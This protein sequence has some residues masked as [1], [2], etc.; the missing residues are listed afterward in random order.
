[1]SVCVT[2]YVLAVIETERANTACVQAAAHGSPPR[3]RP[4]KR[5]QIA[6]FLHGNILYMTLPFARVRN[7]L[8]SSKAP[9]V[10]PAG[11]CLF[12]LLLLFIVP[13][14][15]SSRYVLRERDRGVVAIPKNSSKW[16]YYHRADAEERMHEHMPEGYV[17][18]REEEVVVGQTTKYKEGHP[19]TK[20]NLLLVSF[21]LGGTRGKSTVSDETEYRLYYSRGKTGVQQAAFNQPAD[22]GQPRSDSGSVRPQR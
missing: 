10:K 14:C 6:L 15:N 13:A 9:I 7:V 21:G 18:E 17:V 22:R 5:A 20:I 12:L 2:A 16:P 11:S 1:M 19:G 3:L 8:F 4:P